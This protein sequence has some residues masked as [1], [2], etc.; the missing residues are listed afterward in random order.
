MAR[1][2]SKF[3]DAMH[4]YGLVPQAGVISI[5]ATL[6]AIWLTTKIGGQSL[7]GLLEHLVLIPARAIGPEPWQLVTSNFI[8]LRLVDIFSASL[9]LL[10][11]GN[12]VERQRGLAGVWK[13]FV[14]GGFFGALAAGLVG[15]LIEPQAVL[16]GSM[17]A[18]TA[19]LT[20]FAAGAGS[21]PLNL[22]GTTE[23]RPATMAWIWLGI[24]AFQAVLSL[25]DHPWQTVVLELVMLAG[26]AAAGWVIGG[27]GW[28]F[29]GTFDKISGGA[30][31]RRYV[32]L[33]GGRDGKRWVN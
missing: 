16:V 11:F 23:I 33:Q 9:A 20:A 1:S 32:V 24:S 19:M 8:N 31:R 18:A 22:F 29:R 4:A 21:R 14:I 7:N 28:S 12:A 25:E 13:V 30:K 2:Q 27:G 26:A 15:R 5:L 6:A 10:F 17:G 3:A